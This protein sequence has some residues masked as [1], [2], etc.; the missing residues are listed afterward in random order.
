[1]MDGDELYNLMLNGKTIKEIA[2]MHDT[3]KGIIS[4]A[5]TRYRVANNLPPMSADEINRRIR[6]SR[7]NQN[8]R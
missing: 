3:T 7:S 2:A 4:G 8:D 5:I 6:Q 1:M